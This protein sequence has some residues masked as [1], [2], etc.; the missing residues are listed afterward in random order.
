MTMLTIEKGL[1]QG[2]VRHPSGKLSALRTFRAGRGGKDMPGAAG[3]SP[4]SVSTRRV[5]LQ[6]PEKEGEA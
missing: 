3:G 1:S 2:K 5:F 4:P 6:D